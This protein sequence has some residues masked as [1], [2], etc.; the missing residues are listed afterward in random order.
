M[1][2][3][4]QVLGRFY[5][6]NPEPNNPPVSKLNKSPFLSLVGVML[7]AQT[8]DERTSQACKQLFAV[9]QTPEQIL[10]IKLEDLE[11]LI[12][13][14]GMYRR[15]A[16]LLHKMCDQL[17]VRHRGQVPSER[18]QLLDLA[19]VGRKSVDIIMRFTFNQPA[20][21]VDTHVHRL[22]NR[23]G[24]AYTKTYEQTADI[25]LKDVD[26]QYRWG[27]HEWLIQHGKYVCKSRKPDCG[28]CILNDV[29]HYN[30]SK[31]INSK[32]TQ[33]AA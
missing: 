8:R 27:A 1:K 25:L 20:M 11:K 6:L 15:K 16:V 29:C 12:K 28:K 2:L 7:S 24:V 18:K 26:E 10:E 30:N 19:G 9:A 5:Q 14:V 23:L 21:A 13:P 32:L 4:N 3:I 17:I 22:C 33:E 31:L